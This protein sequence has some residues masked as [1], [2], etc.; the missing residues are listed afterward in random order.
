MI[1]TEGVLT[2]EEDG[3]FATLGAVLDQALTRMAELQQSLQ[4]LDDLML[5]GRPHAIA[6]AAM[7][8]ELSLS[9]AEAV[10]QQIRDA[11]TGLGAARLQDAAKQLRQSDQ[12]TAATAAETLRA[13]LRRFAQQN[14]ACY[15]RAQGLSRGLNASLRA[16]HALGIVENGRLIAEA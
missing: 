10:F 12:T 4:R 1:A 14:A 3:T 11:L 16:L 8:V 7:A 2:A 15:R 13:A 9:N 6:D 5:T